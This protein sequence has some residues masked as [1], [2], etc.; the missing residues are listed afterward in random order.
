MSAQKRNLSYGN[1]LQR[2]EQVIDYR[3]IEI[4]FKLEKSILVASLCFMQR[5]NF[6]PNIICKTQIGTN[7]LNNSSLI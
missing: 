5:L 6:E 2:P 1:I 3:R 4:I 7:F